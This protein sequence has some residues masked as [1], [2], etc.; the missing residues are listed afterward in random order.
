MCAYSL[1]EFLTKSD[2]YV[3]KMADNILDAMTNGEHSKSL[4]E[5]TPEEVNDYSGYFF[6]LL[7]RSLIFSLSFFSLWMNQQMLN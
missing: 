7:K 5:T 3:Y 2:E 6:L 1:S 4:K